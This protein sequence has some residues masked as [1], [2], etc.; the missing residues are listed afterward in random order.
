MPK[1][2][3]K[4]KNKSSNQNRQGHH[5]IFSTSATATATATNKTNIL[6]NM[7]P[8]LIL[9]FISFLDIKDILAF[10]LV[11][12]SIHAIWK[13]K[14]ISYYLQEKI[15]HIARKWNIPISNEPGGNVWLFEGYITNAESLRKLL[16]LLNSDDAK[17]PKIFISNEKFRDEYRKLKNAPEGIPFKHRNPLL[18]IKHFLLQQ[19]ASNRQYEDRNNPLKQ[20]E[21]ANISRENLLCIYS[22]F[23]RNEKPYFPCLYFLIHYLNFTKQVDSTLSKKL[24]ELVKNLHDQYASWLSEK[25]NSSQLQRTLTKDDL[26]NIV[27][28]FFNISYGYKAAEYH[29]TKIMSLLSLL[30]ILLPYFTLEEIKKFDNIKIARFAISNQFHLNIALEKCSRFIVSQRSEGKLSTKSDINTIFDSINEI[31]HHPA[32]KI[33]DKLPADLIDENIKTITISPS[34]ITAVNNGCRLFID[35]DKE[36]FLNIIISRTK[37]N[38]ISAF[39]PL[40][41]TLATE[42]FHKSFASTLTCFEERASSTATLKAAKI[43]KLLAGSSLKNRTAIFK[44]CPTLEK[45]LLIPYS[46]LEFLLQERSLT[47]INKMLSEAGPK[48]ADIVQRKEQLERFFISSISRTKNTTGKKRTRK[49]ATTTDKAST[50]QEKNQASTSQTST[51]ETKSSANKRRRFSK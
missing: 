25:L 37:T 46:A 28:N 17:H 2:Q 39:W 13:E 23:K 15:L 31:Y 3:G 21:Y 36:F 5:T 8:E 44:H 19:R 29:F 11:Y 43:L 32:T 14:G 40:Y 38:V 42:D 45:L 47:V 18:L 49:A 9:T 6:L 33:H 10:I 7:P 4:R 12:R 20:T 26:I 50:A 51:S 48:I 16:T 41:Q 35:M 27:K 30:K 1:G 34:I 24:T 22:V